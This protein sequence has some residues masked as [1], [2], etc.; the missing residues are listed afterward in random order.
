MMNSPLINQPL[1]TDLHLHS[2]ISDGRLSP[3]SLVEKAVEHGLQ[4]IS[5]TDHDTTRGVPTARNKARELGCYFIDG[6]ELETAVKNQDGEEA[7]VHILGYGIDPNNARLNNLM[8]QIQKH[9]VLRAQKITEK[10]ERY[11]DI[12]ISFTNVK[13]HSKGDSLSRV[14]VAQVLKEEG[15]V[16]SIDEAFDR[17]LG[18]QQPAYVS[19][20]APGPAE[21][22]KL[23]HYA[24]GQAVWAHPFYSMNDDLLHPLVEAGLDGIECRHSKF[25]DD[26][27]V[28]Y[29][30]L[31]KKHD[32][33]VTGGS[34][35]HGTLEENFTLGDWWWESRNL[36][37]TFSVG[38]DDVTL[39]NEHPK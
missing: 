16:E 4:L 6:V 33:F 11:C 15:H 31:A 22:I 26:V 27:A 9:R 8:D 2:R 7:S 20:E 29:M 5:L 23:I 32:L 34:D 14:H 37:I 12:N 18:L 30:N 38:P 1:R 25:S 19:R 10:L 35:Y 17:F 3:D 36:P 39:R 28:H 13:N 24:G 21:L